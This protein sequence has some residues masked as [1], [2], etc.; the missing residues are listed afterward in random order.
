MVTAAKT[1]SQAGT[2]MVVGF[3][4]MFCLT[5]STAFGGLAAILE[6]IC[7]VIL[8]PLHE[9]IWKKLRDKRRA[10]RA[11]YAGAAAEKLSQVALH[12]LV[13]FTV[14]YWATGSAAVGGLAAVLEP[15][16]NVILLPI[17]NR[18]WERIRARVERKSRMGR[19][20]AFA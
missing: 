11:G 9:R 14:M 10:R 17:H 4:V 20:G 1:V 19:Q 2:H 3:T 12:M 16:C 15:V 18:L 13:A 5:G 7:N 8:L 6:P